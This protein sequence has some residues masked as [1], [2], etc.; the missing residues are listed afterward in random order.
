MIGPE[1]SLQFC[2]ENI[3][4]GSQ[5]EPAF[6][7]VGY[8]KKFRVFFFITAVVSFSSV[9][10]PVMETSACCAKDVVL[11]TRAIVRMLINL[12]SFIF[13]VFG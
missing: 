5:V 11:T 9:F 12:D 13:V 3:V 4:A 1:K 2:F 7:P 8:D 10:F 6:M